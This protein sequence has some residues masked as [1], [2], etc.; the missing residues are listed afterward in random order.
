MTPVYPLLIAAF[1]KIF[2][3]YSFGAF[4]SAVGLNIVCST[5]T[6]VPIYAVGR[7]VGGVSLGATAAWLWAFF[8][9]TILNTFQSLWDASLDSLLA[10][11]LLWMTLKIAESKS[12]RL[13]AAYGLLWG[14]TLMTNATMASLFPLL[15]GW[16]AFRSGKPDAR[17]L[18]RAA[19][20]LASVT[21]CCVPWTIRNYLAFGSLI[22]LRSTLGLQLWLGNNDEIK[23]RYPGILHPI[24]YSVERTKYVSESHSSGTGSSLCGL[25]ARLILFQTSPKFI[26]LGSDPFYCSTS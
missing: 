12:L 6:C 24:S 13:W 20:A 4:L 17:F 16:A 7:R 26:Q 1:F 8:P 9:N 22:P 21:L 23:G 11:T 19:I 15:A 10:A 2:G 25:A 14:F 18:S 5:L 3:T